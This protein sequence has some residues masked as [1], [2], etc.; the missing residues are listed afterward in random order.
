MFTLTRFR[1]EFLPPTPGNGINDDDA[2]LSDHPWSAHYRHL[3]TLSDTTKPS[4]LSRRTASPY[5]SKWGAQGP[6]LII[7][8]SQWEMLQT[9]QG[10]DIYWKQ[11]QWVRVPTNDGYYQSR[12]P[13]P[14]PKRGAFG[15]TDSLNGVMRLGIARDPDDPEAVAAAEGQGSQEDVESVL[16]EW[17]RVNDPA[18]NLVEP[19]VKEEEQMKHEEG[20]PMLLVPSSTEEQRSSRRQQEALPT[21]DPW[22]DPM[23]AFQYITATNKDRSRRANVGNGIDWAFVP[24]GTRAGKAKEG[25][26]LLDAIKVFGLDVVSLA[27]GEEGDLDRWW[28]AVGNLQ[29]EELGRLDTNQ[30]AISVQPA[31]NDVDD[32]ASDGAMS[33]ESSPERPARKKRR[34]NEPTPRRDRSLPLRQDR[35]S[36][37]EPASQ[38]PLPVP[39]LSSPPAVQVSDSYEAKL[40]AMMSAAA[41]PAPQ[42]TFHLT[43]TGGRV[44]AT[45]S[46]APVA[47]AVAPLPDGS[48]STR[49]APSQARSSRH[50]PVSIRAGRQVFDLASSPASERLAQSSPPDVAARSS[51]DLPHT[52]V[53][54]VIAS[55]TDYSGRS[56]AYPT[57]QAT[58]ITPAAKRQ[59]QRVPETSQ[60]TP[61]KRKAPSPP[62]MAICTL[63]PA[64]RRRTRLDLPPG[65][66]GLSY[67]H[68]DNIMIPS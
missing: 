22:A 57:T 37:H 62:A 53:R 28:F 66:L 33:W 18:R 24:F 3:A 46:Q 10:E 23:D 67:Q 11:A 68:V 64:P 63:P 42:P 9:G 51:G 60:P 27:G 44:Q 52:Q 58:A 43:A 36:Q 41:G 19:Q 61:L 12:P 13:P 4:Y 1:F 26:R 30:A 35:S 47:V 7:R 17:W 29:Q 55:A 8:A 5:V 50:R 15:R 49:V 21:M 39:P 38:E 59:S 31:N 54:I 14:P 32:T 16:R 25:R 34:Q 20:E 40:Q 56:V 2:N 6:E 48:S 65:H 45:A